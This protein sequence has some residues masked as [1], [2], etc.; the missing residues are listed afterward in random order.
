VPKIRAFSDLP[1]LLNTY[2]MLSGIETLLR[3]HGC[4]SLLDV[5]CGTSSPL[6]LLRFSGKTV[7]I[8]SFPPAIEASKRAG[9]HHEYICGQIENIQ[10]PAKSFDAVIALELIEHLPKER[11]PAFL[12][13]LER[14][15]R[16]IVIISTPNGYVPQGPIAGN[17]FQEHLCGWNVDELQSRGYAINGILGLKTLRGAEAKLTVKPAIVGAALSKVSEP[18]VWGRPQRAFGLLAH[19]AVAAP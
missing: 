6:R 15:A 7:G 18:F 16:R 1:S 19:K 17:P 8:D 5:G 9:I 11:G 10:V 13:D 3:Q 12:A 4:A 14:I 2:Q